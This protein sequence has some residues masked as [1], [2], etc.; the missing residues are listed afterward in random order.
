MIIVGWQQGSRNLWYPQSAADTRAV[1]ADIATVSNM[2]IV[3]QGADPASFY[4][5]GHSLGS[6]V[7]GHAGNTARDKFGWKWGR[8]TGMTE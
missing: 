5:A 8:I 3:T 7:C 1:G 2:I 6:H 4:C